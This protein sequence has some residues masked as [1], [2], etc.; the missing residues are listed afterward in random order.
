MANTIETPGRFLGARTSGAGGFG[1]AAA[2]P[3]GAAG[4]LVGFGTDAAK[5][6]CGGS[7]KT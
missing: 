3:G 4:T 7:A 5:R 6:G 1:M 2:K